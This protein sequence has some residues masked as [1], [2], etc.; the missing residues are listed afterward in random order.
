MQYQLCMKCYS[1]IKIIG[2]IFIFAPL[3]KGAVGRCHAFDEFLPVAPAFFV[4]VI[5]ISAFCHGGGCLF[6]GLA[7]VGIEP[8]IDVDIEGVCG[9]VVFDVGADVSSVFFYGVVLH[10]LGGL[11]LCDTPFLHADALPDGVHFIVIIPV[12]LF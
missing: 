10:P 8:D 12:Y 9:Q 2:T 11:L 4:R 5:G 7:V 3:N 6:P 1:F